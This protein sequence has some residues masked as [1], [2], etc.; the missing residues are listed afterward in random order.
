MLHYLYLD[1]G[2]LPKYR[3]ELKYSLISLRQELGA[4]PGARI[5]IYTDTP[6]AYANWP[7]EVVDIGPRV[8]EWSGGGLYPHRIKPAAV[9]DALRRFAGPVCFVDSDTI[10]K[11]G[12]HAEV[13]EKMAPQEMWSVTKTAVVMNRF[14][15]MNPFP[16][17]KGFATRLPH[18][19]RY[20]YDRAN[21]WMFNSGL[22]GASPV[23]VPILEDALVFIDALIGRARKFPTLEQFALSEVVR[24]NQIPVAEVRDS[25]V[26]YWQ[27]RRRIYMANQIEKAL[28]PDWDD[29]TPPK[30]WAKMNTWAVRA[31]N[32]YYGITHMF[33]GWRSK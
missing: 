20:H 29:L 23:H 2:G 33:D 9:L 24:L 13:T 19:G 28:S 3:R 5:A 16:P 7:M 17:L 11:P 10:V 12:F 6:A 18:L 22:I 31:Y 14:E 1:Y 25:F 27:G 15:L 32:Y 30:E 4:E 8:R 26:H 21:S